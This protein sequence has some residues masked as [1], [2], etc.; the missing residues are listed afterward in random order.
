VAW[1]NDKKSHA[2]IIVASPDA[3]RVQ[4]LLDEYAARFAQDFLAV[5][6][7]LDHPPD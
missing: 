2:G 4:T 7:P 3:D 5:L 1:R 6:P